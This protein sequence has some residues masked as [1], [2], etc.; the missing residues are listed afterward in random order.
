MCSKVECQHE[1]L[2]V[3]CNCL[4]RKQTSKIPQQTIGCILL[5]WQLALGSSVL[6]ACLPAL[7]QALWP[8]YCLVHSVQRGKHDTEVL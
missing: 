6:H 1:H 3:G 4:V 8:S 5:S 7:K 2:M